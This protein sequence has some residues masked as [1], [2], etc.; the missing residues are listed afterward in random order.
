MEL[1]QSSRAA[2][3]LHLVIAFIID[4]IELIFMSK[5]DLTQVNLQLASNLVINNQFRSAVFLAFYVPHCRHVNSNEPDKFC[6]NDKD[7]SNTSTLS[8]LFCPRQ[9]PGIQ[10]LNI[11]ALSI[12]P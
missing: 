11:L 3:C 4:A 12:H 7:K 10:C 5:T 2:R 1:S 6:L 9:R 8:H